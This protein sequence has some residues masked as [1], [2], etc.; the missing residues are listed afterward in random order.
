MA[1]L[2]FRYGVVS[3]AKTLNL[4][5]TL[6]NYEQQG[7]KAVLI[8]P[9]IDT[10]SPN[11]ESRAGLSHIPD[12]LL[13]PEDD[14][15]VALYPYKQLGISAILVDEVQFLTSPQIDYLRKLSAIGGIP[16]L[17]YGLRTK[18]DATLWPSIVT[19]MALA[20]SI[21]EIKT[22]CAYCSSK[23]IFSKSV[24]QE[25]IGEDGIKLTW[26]EFIPVCAKHFYLPKS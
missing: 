22:E 10:R 8:K 7:K 1:K 12:I 6:H 18:S 21:E 24:S 16:V 20:D 9:A 14:L 17:C 25:G 11:V 3:S 23:A 26:D 19:L 13:K 2:Y 5:A 4:L 15:P